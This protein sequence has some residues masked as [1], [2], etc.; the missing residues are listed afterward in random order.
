[1]SEKSLQP[2][3][4]AKVISVTR[5]PGRPDG[6]PTV[7]DM[8]DGLSRLMD[9]AFQLPGTN[10]RFGLNSILLLLPILGDLI[11]T[12]VSAAIVAIG[13]HHYRVPRIVAARMVL[14]SL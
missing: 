14:N 8:L 5:L 12:L 7:L 6:S 3:D 9:R 13:L 10:I 11:P 1:M 2:I 4:Y